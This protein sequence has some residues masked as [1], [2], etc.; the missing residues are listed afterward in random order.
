MVESSTSTTQSS[1]TLTTTS[2]SSQISTSLT[3]NTSTNSLQ[4]SINSTDTQTSNATTT[5]SVIT[6]NQTSTS[7]NSAVATPFYYSISINYTGS[8]KLVYSGQNG[9]QDFQG[10][11]S[12]SGYFNT[13]IVTYGVGYVENKL[14]ATAMKLDSQNIT[15][16]L[17]VVGQSSS[18]TPS[19]PSTTVCWTQAV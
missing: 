18:T 13:T 4:T 8:W 1:Q 15:L 12:G 17:R 11:K 7:T 5:Q 19:D 2:K 10:N 16:T 3:T 9:T 6:T 14:C